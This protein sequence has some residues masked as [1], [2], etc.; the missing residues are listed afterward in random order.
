[1]ALPADT[2]ADADRAQIEAYRRMGEAGRFAATFRLIALARHLSIDGIRARHPDYTD[3]QVHL[4]FARLVL[5]D[6]LA[7][8][9]APGQPLVDP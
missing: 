7:A 2:A 1:M 4:A 8:A 6:A 3:E 5:G 9:A